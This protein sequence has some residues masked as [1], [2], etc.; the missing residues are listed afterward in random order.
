[1]IKL[2]T[3]IYK[4]FHSHK[5]F[6]H[7]LLLIIF[8]VLCFFACKMKYEEDVSKILPST[9]VG[10]TGDIVFGNVKVKDKVFVLFI[11]DNDSC[12][13]DELEAAAQDFSEQLMEKDST[14][15]LI[16]NILYKL[17]DDMIPSLFTFLFENIPSFIDSTDFTK[18]EEL[19]TEENINFRMAQN[20]E[21]LST[22]AGAAY[23]PI[24]ANDPIGFQDV[25]MEKA[26]IIQDG[27][28]GN[29]TMIDEFFFTPDSSSAIAFISPNFDSFESKFA[30][31]MVNDMKHL[32]K[33]FKETYPNVKIVY[34]GAPIEGS[35]NSSHIIRDIIVTIGSSL[36]IIMIIII[37]C[38]RKPLHT[39]F[40]LLFPIVFGTIFGL[41]IMYFIKGIM[42]FLALGIG[43]LILAVGLSYCLHVL[44]HF[45]HTG[46]ALTVVKDQTMPIFLSCITTI[47]AFMALLFTSSELLRDFG[48]FASLVLIGCAFSCIIFQPQFF[49]KGTEVYSEKSFRFLNKIN[50]YPIE[51]KKWIS[52]VIIL[53]FVVCLFTQRNVQFDNDL[54][55]IGY[56][57]PLM[58]YSQQ[59]L[60]EKTTPGYYTKYYATTATSLDSAIYRYQE[61]CQMLE[62]AQEAG[63]IHSFGKAGSLF[64]STDEQQKRIDRWNSFWTEE[65]KER[66]TSMVSKAAI[67]FGFNPEFFT[68]FHNV[69]NAEYKPVNILESDLLPKS[70]MS[71]MAEKCGDIYMIFTPVQADEKYEFTFD[72]EEVIAKDQEHFIVLDPM[73]YSTDMV[74]IINNDFNTILI[75]SVI[76]VLII[77]LIHFRSILLALLAFLPMFVS[78]YTMLGIM[79]I[80]GIKF[81]LINIVVSSLIFGVGVDYSIFIMDGLI[82][83]GRN[84]DTNLLLFHKTAILFSAMTLIICSISLMFASHSAISSVGGVTLIGMASTILTTYTLQPLIFKF[85]AKNKH[86]GKIIAKC[87]ERLCK[88]KNN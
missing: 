66:I 62:K 58:L 70:I 82:E 12:S 72:T 75:I 38:F 84:T 55:N 35:D 57:N 26:G 13:I 73:F 11:K 3:N 14:H 56:K 22:E 45:K 48:L 69:I 71:N 85:L 6:F 64:V 2:S 24:I 27:L 47:G 39:I 42:S 30:R 20:L 50:S 43:V 34:H 59:Y 63:H 41:T 40:S 16:D 67:S 65:N 60:K 44:T 76:F 49:T 10:S 81:N 80:I 9:N 33:E 51:D 83:S 28:G 17:D 25:F 15:H 29:Y 18:L 86:T 21:L 88:S 77:L 74:S 4:Y 31:V 68:P 32:T 54:R 37:I 1:M 79:G 7:I 52:I 87:S 53:L 78:W 36:I 19:C 8:I 46:N 23:L 61:N 5:T